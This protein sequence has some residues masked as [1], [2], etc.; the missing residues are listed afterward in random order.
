M[1][2]TLYPDFAVRINKLIS[3]Y[4][5]FHHMKLRVTQGLRTFEEQDKLYELG[6]ANSK[7]MVTN[8]RGGYSFHNFGLAAD[9]CF[10]SSDPYLVKMDKEESDFYWK[11]LGR[12]GKMFDLNWGGDFSSPDRCHFEKDY[13][14]E[15]SELR[16]VYLA[17]GITDLWAVIDKKQ[18]E[19][20]V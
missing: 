1:I 8:S 4:G 2:E 13:G 10:V 6:R 20:L 11:E 19:T 7:P 17:Y 12:F 16:R 14:F 15:L 3:S 5:E 9:L 18:K